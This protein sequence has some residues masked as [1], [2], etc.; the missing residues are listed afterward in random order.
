MQG[1]KHGRPYPTPL[2]F[3]IGDLV[4]VHLP[5]REAPRKGVIRAISADRLAVVELQSDGETCNGSDEN[6]TRIR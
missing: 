1:N 5:H 3:Y 4:E 2:G 6:L